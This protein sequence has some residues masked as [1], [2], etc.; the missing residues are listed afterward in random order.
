MLKPQSLAAALAN[1]VPDLS[2][3]PARFQCHVERG[4]LIATATP[5]S[6]FE[7][8]YQLTLFLLDYAGPADAIF[9]PLLGWMQINQPEQFLTPDLRDQAIV[10]DVDI[11]DGD[12]SNIEIQLQ[13]TE[14]VIV[15]A[16]EGGSTVLTH[17]DEPTLES[18]LEPIDGVPPG[19]TLGS[20][21]VGGDTILGG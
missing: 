20:I 4:R 3:D 13:L 9:W 15:S 6:G 17:I 10:F 11:L 5:G 21:T 8:R 12:R 16:G 19:R 7:Y 1:A 2:T 14:S 18:L